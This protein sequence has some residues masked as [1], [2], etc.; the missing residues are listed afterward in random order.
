MHMSISDSPSPTGSRSTQ[1][2]IIAHRPAVPLGSATLQ[3]YAL[4]IWFSVRLAAP[5]AEIVR[6]AGPASDAWLPS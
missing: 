6:D 3:R 5:E 2:K 1:L 4:L